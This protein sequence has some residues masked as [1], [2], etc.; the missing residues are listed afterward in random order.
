MILDVFIM[1]TDLLTVQIIQYSSLFSCFLFSGYPLL[2]LLFP[3]WIT[4][5]WC[6]GGFLLL[7]DKDE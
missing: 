6:F 4:T 2:P 1:S 3:L 7:L 5:L